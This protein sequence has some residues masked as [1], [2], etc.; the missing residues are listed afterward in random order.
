[1]KARQLSREL[2]RIARREVPTGEP[3]LWPAIRRQ[4]APRGDVVAPAG[5]QR[6]GASRPE[7]ESVY[8]WRA[9]ERR[10]RAS[11]GVRALVAVAVLVLVGSGLAALLS[12]HGGSA[13]PVGAGVTPSPMAAATPA[14]SASWTSTGALTIPIVLLAGAGVGGEVRA[15]IM[16][17]RDLL[18]TV[19]A[20]GS[21]AQLE[22][23]VVTSP[24]VP[25]AGQ[26]ATPDA[27]QDVVP[28]FV[29]SGGATTLVPAAKTHQPLTLVGVE[30][31]TGLPV[32]RVTVPA[33]PEGMAITYRPAAEVPS[34]CPVTLPANPAFMPPV[35]YR[36]TPAYGT[37]F[38]YGTAA[39]WTA[40]PLGGTWDGLPQQGSAYF[41]KVF[42]WDPDYPAL[43]SQD[44]ARWGFADFTVT[45]RRLDGNAPPLAADRATNATDGNGTSILVGVTFPTAG[46]WEVTGEYQGHDLS[47]VIWVGGDTP[48]TATP[49]ATP[50]SA[51]L[52]HDPTLQAL[53]SAAGFQLLVPN[54]LPAGVSLGP[55]KPPMRLGTF[56]SAVM[57]FNSVSGP[58]MLTITEASPYQDSRQTMPASEFDSAVPVDPGGGVTGYLYRGTTQTELWWQVGPISIRLSTGPW[59]AGTPEPEVWALSP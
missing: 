52:E 55:L 5:R 56:T 32:G 45:G 44:P 41:Q 58:P 50:G 16:P 35:P 6:S 49:S 9:N 39:L 46:C 15:Q 48:A 33:V 51:G 10:G 22:W 4:I 42:W 26:I 36:G 43:L 8:V 28:P 21:G 59:P 2:R 14:T 40:L 18:L 20:A 7:V 1:M 30:L 12:S 23:H 57:A 19:Q 11:A 3:D 54:W 25:V 17:S 53:Q 27:R 24:L 31:S 34:T 13:L 38:W 47:F 37:Q 29:Q